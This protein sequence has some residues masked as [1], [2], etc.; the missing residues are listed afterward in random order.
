MHS[1]LREWEGTGWTQGWNFQQSPK[2]R[3]DLGVAMPLVVRDG[4]V[5]DG[6]WQYGWSG[7]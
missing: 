1:V 7:N 2:S 5:I 4:H 6:F 3:Y